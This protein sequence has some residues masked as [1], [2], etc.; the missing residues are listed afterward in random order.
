LPDG[1]V[2]RMSAWATD[3]VF[4]S[5]KLCIYIIEHRSRYPA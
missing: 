5:L 1:M 3:Q 2:E 4:F